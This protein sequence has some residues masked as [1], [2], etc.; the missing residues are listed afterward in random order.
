[1]EK[2]K[3]NQIGGEKRDCCAH[4]N[5]KKDSKLFPVRDD[6]GKTVTVHSLSPKWARKDGCIIYIQG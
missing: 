3:S 6:N 4:V 1:M 5:N 2:T